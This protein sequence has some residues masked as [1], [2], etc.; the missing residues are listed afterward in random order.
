MEREALL[1]Y[2]APCSLLCYTCSGY[3]NGGISKCAN[4]LCQYFEGYYD[5]IDAVIPEENRGWLQE[6]QTFYDRLVRYADRPCLGCRSDVKSG[7]I[8]GCVVPEC[9]REK[10][11]DFCAECPEFP[12]EKGKRF[13]AGINNM[14]GKDWENGNRRII[15]VG[16]E[17]YFE[18]KKDASHYKS[19][20]K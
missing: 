15:E 2:V 12:C 7:C 11:I 10:G 3:K 19:Y 5:F 1:Q 6:F 14:I 4:Q 16:I 13:F 18:E 17:R 9:I 8:E 20:K